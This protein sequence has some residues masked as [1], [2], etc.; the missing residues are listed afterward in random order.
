MI[1]SPE[2]WR[3]RISR[4]DGRV[5]GAG[6]LVDRQKVLTCAHVVAEALGVDPR[7]AQPTESVQVDFPSLAGVKRLG[8]VVPGGWVPM[9][10]DGRGDIAVLMLD[11][12]TPDELVP[13][14]LR[15]CGQLAEDRTVRS[16]GHPAGIED[17]VWALTRLVGFGGPGGEWIQM[18]GQTVTGRRVERGFSGAG[19]IDERSGAV[20]GL[21]IAEDV[22][23]PHKVAWMIPMELVARYLPAV[24]ALLEEASGEPE[25]EPAPRQPGAAAE[26]RLSPA[27]QRALF[28]K[29]W[30]VPGMRDRPARDLYLDAL[31]QRLGERVSFDRQRDSLLDVW[32][33]M[34]A[35]LARPG[36]VRVLGEVLAEIHRSNE[37]VAALAELI[38]RTFP[39]LLLH[40]AERV[41]LEQLVAGVGWAKVGAAYRNAVA[42]LGMAVA[43]ERMDTV[44]VIRRLESFGRLRGG[45]PPPLL[46]FV[47]DLAHKIGGHTSVELHRW[48]DAV[49]DRLELD[50]GALRQL[51]GAAEQRRSEAGQV[52]FVVQL[53]PDSVDPERYLMSAWLRQGRQPERPLL[54]DDVPRTLAEAE[55]A[56]DDLLRSVPEHASVEIEELAVEF[57]L[58]RRLLNHPVDRW[59][60]DRGSFPRP[61]GIQYP[62]VVRSLERLLDRS[63]HDAWRRKSRW[64][65]EHGYRPDPAA[66]WCVLQPPPTNPVALYAQLTQDDRTICLALPFPPAEAGPPGG[67]EFAAGLAAGMPVIVWSREPTDPVGFCT[68][69]RDVLANE[70]VAEIARRLLWLRRNAMKTMN[71]GQQGPNLAPQVGL[72]WD[73]ADQMPGPFRRPPRLHAPQ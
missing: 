66:V 59:E 11:E 10:E 33:M 22:H 60:F 38:E 48:V 14:S 23:A 73:D 35:L 42:H 20:V 51:C 8:S 50:R 28:D 57:I 12:P 39:D 63:L 41:E 53:H 55:L 46:V 3:V 45:P 49:G 61:L 47:D 4:P 34:L 62:V 52:V 7:G 9:A 56:V 44:L 1:V 6:V 72:L 67:D 40:H 27:E 64:L 25:P 2:A 69:V 32:A 16:Y 30:A 65:A 18:D 29:L 37:A 71:K 43:V 26:R 54:R 24:F 15:P 19:A 17:G 5:F 31:E 13:A 58:P 68:T 70:G 36:A 21:V